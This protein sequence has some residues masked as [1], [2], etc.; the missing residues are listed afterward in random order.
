MKSKVV[1]VG[2]KC[3]SC[4]GLSKVPVEKCTFYGNDPT[5]DAGYSD[6][7]YC[8]VEVSLTCPLC[9]AYNCVKLRPADN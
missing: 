4:G 9:G 5:N 6:G 3:G 8:Y 2:Y 1:F 7:Y